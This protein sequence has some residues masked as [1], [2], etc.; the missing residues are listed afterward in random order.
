[1]L[2][3]GQVCFSSVAWE[4]DRWLSAKCREKGQREKDWERSLGLVST[5]SGKGESGMCSENKLL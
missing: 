3:T 4:V 2:A 1:M 5:H